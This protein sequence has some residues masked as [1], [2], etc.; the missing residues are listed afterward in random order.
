MN[1]IWN[2]TNYWEVRKWRFNFSDKTKGKKKLR[3]CENILCFDIETSNGYIKNNVVEGWDYNKARTEE[4][5]GIFYFDNT[6]PV[7][8]MYV[9]QCAVEHDDTIDVVMGRT[10]EDFKQFLLE[11]TETITLRAYKWDSATLQEPMRSN[12]LKQCHKKGYIGLHM[13]IHNLGFE[14]QHL[15]NVFEE[16]FSRSEHSVFA[17]S[18]R[19]PMKVSIGYNYCNLTFHDT[20]CLTQKSLDNWCKDSNL[21]V[22]KL[23]GTFDYNLIRTPETELTQTEISYCVNDVVS[24][25][26][27]IKQ[28]RDKY[29]YLSNI[30]MTQTGEVRRKC[31]DKIAKT[32]TNWSNLCRD[33]TQNMTFDEYTRLVQCFLGGWTHANA[34]YTGKK[35]LNLRCFDFRSS[36]PGVM[37]SRKFPVS[38]F[39]PCSDYDIE[40]YEKKDINDRDYMYYVLVEFKN[41]ISNKFNTFWS[42]SKC[43]EIDNVVADNGRIKECDYLKCYMTDLDFDV[44]RKV[45][46]FE[47]CN[48]LEAYSAKADYLPTSFINVILD[49]YG[50]KTSLKDTGRDSE[51]NEAKQFINSLY[52]VCVT[53]IITD[54][55]TFHDGWE[56]TMATGFDYEETIEKMTKKEM[57]YTY[58]LGVWVT[59]WARH[60]LWDA[61]QHLDF[62]TVYCDTDSIK[63]M[64]TDEDL[65]WFDNYNKGVW[66][67]CMKCATI[68]HINP[69]LYRPKTPKG[70]LKEIGWFDREHDCLE[71]KTLGAKRYVCLVYDEKKQCNVIETT[72]AG[73]PKR[74]GVKLITSV[75]DFTEDNRWD[76]EES[77]KLNSCYNENQPELTWTDHNGDT[78][79]SKDRYGLNL[80]PTTFELGVAGEYRLLYNMLQNYDNDIMDTPQIIRINNTKGLT[81]ENI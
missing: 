49:Y 53:K 69:D 52:G 7:S 73:L 65:K 81:G 40:Q 67:Q 4:A 45:Y 23:T 13:Y 26:Y 1:I 33:V 57:F 55:V 15:R 78:Y 31:M 62:K 80:M 36:Y 12:I 2:N 42:T 59:A 47:E 74:S 64:F 39:K 16:A 70:K 5:P 63:G 37:V 35:L 29:V 54:N 44:F 51:Y 18:T 56:K 21:P 10:W 76:W 3:D 8:L 77:E 28:Y 71:F 17:R 50:N 48:I 38:S 41:V 27:G 9:W 58:Q 11:L 68:R 46:D 22:Q 60:N 30:P 61:I 14:F 79:V 75:D 19:K 20:L 72:I 34:F 66:D 32:D 6:T 24:M 25:V 43:V